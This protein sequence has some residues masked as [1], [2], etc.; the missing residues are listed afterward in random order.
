MTMK[1]LLKGLLAAAMALSL[2]GCGGSSSS[3]GTSSGGLTEFHDYQTL[4]NE[5]ETWNILHSQSAADL[6]YLT[7][8]IDGLLTNNTKG[9]LVSNIAY[10]WETNEDST[11]WTFHLTE[12][13]KWVDVNGEEKGEVTAQ[14]WITGLEYVLN[15]AKNAGANSSMPCEMIKGAEE[16]YEM[17]LEESEANN[18]VVSAETEAKFTEIVGIEAVDEY[19][20]VY[21]MKSP[22]PYFD[23]LAAY[24]CL[25]PLSQAALD[26]YGDDYGTD[27][28]TIYYCGPYICTEYTNGAY[29]T[30]TQN[31]T[32]WNADNNTRFEKV[33]VQMVEDSQ[34]AW[35]LFQSG[36][37]DYV[38][39]SE[40]A[41]TEIQ[42]AGEGSTYYDYLVESKPTKY[43]YVMH[44]NYNA[45][46]E[47]GSDDTNWNTAI[48]NKNF[49]L[50]WYYGVDY[51]SLLKR[52]NSTNPGKCVYDCYT[53]DSLCF[54]S[55]GTDYTTLVQEELGY[56]SE[57]NSDSV[58]ARIDADK[59]AEVKEAAI[60]EL[61]AAGVELPVTCYY[62]Y[63]NGNSTGAD[64]ATIFKQMVES[65]LEGL[66]QV[67]F[68]TYTTSYTQEIRNADLFSVVING[69][70]ADYGDPMNYLGQ[71]TDSSDAFYNYYYSNLTVD[72]DPEYQV[73]LDLVAEA[74]A[75]VNDN[76]ARYAAFAKAEAYWI[77]QA[78]GI[79]LYRDIH[80][81]LTRVNDYSKIAGMYGIQANRYINWETTSNMAYTSAEYEAFAA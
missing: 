28:T 20:L 34:M 17:T 68:R 48:A 29:K 22:K 62:C 33:T 55:D 65:Q 46:N 78:Y 2:V 18:G 61:T 5:M 72:I 70:G 54:T 35:N 21:T 53:K 10:D 52:V 71:E 45:K 43:A 23:T 3:E 64:T 57:N 69:W 75:I 42:M 24:N 13:V 47:D 30:F 51:T 8:F 37:L 50:C 41:L 40:D 16:Y 76:D 19:T 58:H 81:E 49:R 38:Q 26:E 56:T 66:V 11:V 39:L 6:N 67:E 36:E 44:F 15:Y 74:D 14:D 1:K 79:P 63:M 80:W 31:P 27:N 12:G 7:N 32:W 60:E 73:F 25:Y 4:A 77:T 9:E 59:L